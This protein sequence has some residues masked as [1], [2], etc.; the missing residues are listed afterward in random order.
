MV[1]SNSDS[2][3]H[4]KAAPA[5]TTAQEQRLI[6]AWGDVAAAQRCHSKQKPNGVFDSAASYWPAGSWPI[7]GRAHVQFP[8]PRPGAR[9]EGRTNAPACRRNENELPAPGSA[10]IAFLTPR[11]SSSVGGC[12]GAHLWRPLGSSSGSLAFETRPAGPGDPLQSRPST[13]LRRRTSHHVEARRHNTVGPRE[14]VQRLVTRVGGEQGPR[15]V[16]FVKKS[17]PESSCLTC[18]VPRREPKN[19]RLEDYEV[20]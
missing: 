7:S 2:P 9:K 20:M 13:D 15:Q 3:H 10:S 14:M 19:T 17:P 12:R 8:R 18:E 1:D 6:Q 11:S 4:H 16:G 5:E